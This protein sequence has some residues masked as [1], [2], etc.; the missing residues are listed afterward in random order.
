M[1]FINIRCEL[2][3]AE[4]SDVALWVDVECWVVALIGEEGGYT[5]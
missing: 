1:E 2:S 3:S 4:G 5:G